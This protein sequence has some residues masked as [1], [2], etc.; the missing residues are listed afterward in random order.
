MRL[1]TG[2]RRSGAVFSAITAWCSTGSGPC[3]PRPLFPILP[4]PINAATFLP[5][6]SS[7]LMFVTLY[8]QIAPVIS[9][10]FRRVAGFGENC[11]PIRFRTAGCS[12][13]K[14]C[15]ELR[16][17]AEMLILV[18]GAAIGLLR[19]PLYGL[20][21][22]PLILGG[23]V[24]FAAT[25]ILLAAGA[26][27]MLERLFLRT[28]L[29]EAMLFL[30]IGGGRS[31]AVLIFMDVRKAALVRFAPSQLFWPWAAVARLMLSRDYGVRAVLLEC[32][33]GARLSRGGLFFRAMAIR[34]QQSG[35]TQAV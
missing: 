15:C 11:S 28:R 5:V 10:G 30:L 21:C 16:T 20:K 19:N 24:I 17:G 32:R 33:R 6:L 26:R 29:R 4:I 31:A 1:R 35:M 8:W 34:A 7:G 14:F 13:W 22:S 27:Y 3:L 2:T 18:A 25:N 23:A 9:A 12:R